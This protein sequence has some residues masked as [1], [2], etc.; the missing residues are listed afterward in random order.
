[1][2]SIE[3][4]IT[5]LATKV[6]PGPDDRQRLGRLLP[7]ADKDCL[8]D[9]ATREGLAGLFYKSFLHAGLLPDFSPR[10][11]ERLRFYYYST[12]RSNLILIRDATEIL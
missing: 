8:I 3:W 2:N 11:Q 9:T 5:A 7:A 10:Q 6:L 1:M 12:V 4:K